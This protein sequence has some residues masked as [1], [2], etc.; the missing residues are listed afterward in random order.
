MQSEV[1]EGLQLSPQQE[2]VWLMHEESSVYVAQCAILLDGTPDITR[3]KK[4]VFAVVQR[5]E[6]LHSLFS[7]P[8]RFDLPF[9]IVDEDCF[10]TWHECDLSGERGAAQDAA[11]DELLEAQS[12]EPFN[13]ERGPLVR[14]THCRLGLDRYLLAI[15]MPAICCD[16]RSLGNLFTE[17]A[18][19]Y[20]SLQDNTR[21]D[22]YQYADFAQWQHEL[23][24]EERSNAGKDFWRKQDFATLSPV[25]LPFEKRTSSLSEFAP[26]RC[27]SVVGKRTLAVL[28]ALSREMHTD[29]AVVLLAAWQI[30]LWRLSGTSSVVVGQ[31]F[32]GR[33]HE[34]LDDALGLYAKCLPV[35]GELHEHLRFVDIVREAK[36]ATRDARLWQDYFTWDDNGPRKWSLGGIPYFRFGFE[37]N[38]RSFPR[39][40]AGLRFSIYSQR[41]C[42][43]RFELKLACL[44][45]QGGMTAEF[46][47]D[48][49]TFVEEDI[50]LLA[51]QFQKLL[52]G[53]A[54]RP[55]ATLDQL[56]LITE[57]EQQRL[58]NFNPQP[59]QTTEDRRVHELFA[60][61]AQRTPDSIALVFEDKQITYAELDARSNQL[62]HYLRSH[63]VGPEV[64]VAI[65]FDRSAEFVWTML[66]ILKAGAAYLPLD[67]G[68][69]KVRIDHILQQASPA[70]VI[71]RR[72]HIE[73]LPE[74]AARTIVLDT[75]SEE[76]A[77]QPRSAVPRSVEPANLAY[78]LFTSGST[79][80]PKG[81]AIEHRQ[82][83]NY[84][85]SIT[86][87]LALTPGSSY[88]T[89]STFAADLGH[90][91]IFPALTTG[92][93]LHVISSER[94]Y[95]GNRLARYFSDHQIDVLKIVPSHLEA[96]Q[97]G[98]SPEDLM[99][100][101]HLILGGEASR[102]E[103]VD[104]L[105]HLNPSGRIFNHYGP[106][107]TTVG[108][109]TY[110]V[111]TDSARRYL[112][113]LPL[114]RPLDET[115]VYLLDRRFRPVPTWVAGEIYIGGAGVA[116]GYLN[117]PDLTAARFLP[118]PFSAKPGARV[119]KT[120]D[121]ARFWPDEQLEFIGRA[122]HQVKL[123]GFRIELGEIEAA[124]AEH[125]G[126]RENVVIVSHD[127][128]GNDSRLVAYIVA[129]SL[130]P[131][132]AELRQYLL[133]HL[134]DYM[135]PAVFVFIPALPLNSNG[136]VDQ[137]RLPPP[138]QVRPELG[139]SYVAPRSA[140]EQVVANIWADVLK[141]DRVGI[142]DN[143]FEL[144]GHS[145][146]L[147]QL[148]SRLR[149]TFQVELPPRIIFEAD[150]VERLSAIL[151]AGEPQAGLTEK[152]AQI[153]MQV[154]TMSPEEAS[155]N[156]A[157]LTAT[158]SEFTEHA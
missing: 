138:D 90:T 110:A 122:D 141:L 70:A 7:C 114:G 21:N 60:E 20:E 49:N 41:A 32:E 153:V 59:R 12:S 56:Q 149:D 133:E 86:N 23:L 85:E 5:H 9:Q 2:R 14:I 81:V 101:S 40:T 151:I 78:A 50:R 88:A 94:L 37:Y 47:Y 76:I 121:L 140:T 84:V 124:L 51:N 155:N 75:D 68:W 96:L 42:V 107:E 17:I 10:P 108:V 3:L 30:L 69:P 87:R 104:R 74:H 91:A 131:T 111:G 157:L 97:S 123:H 146:L 117:S 6:I 67:L 116:R 130:A 77:Q 13:F 100:R 28:E 148:T 8:D 126:V 82:L 43:E 58:R 34:E 22:P 158:S 52:D 102:H 62:A 95:D 144:G 53:I 112:S 125:P 135:V 61:Q 24:E 26:K 118:D 54:E 4:S 105:S 103:W 44:R 143:F 83:V 136:K 31:L 120:G 115:Q 129:E 134:P 57:V 128:A 55:N 66:G 63:G 25:R 109:L 71:T 119:Y 45:D 106:T 137:K 36:H 19:H 73:N 147:M 16:G 18:G 1:I 154:E 127:V 89:V 29:L 64:L 98:A 79:G 38:E 11:I 80:T 145:L 46:H 132:T 99:P 156:L 35:A 33:S 93:R 48:P 139:Q 65:F 39:T 15:T 150:T 72:R 152:I 27:A 113:T 142:H 92:G